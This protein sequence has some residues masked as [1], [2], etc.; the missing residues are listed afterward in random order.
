[1]T[2]TDAPEQLRLFIAI[3]LPESV[4]DA[5]EKA[6]RELRAAVRS[7]GV[8]WTK[9]EQFHL[10]LKF[11]GNVG[12]DRVGALTAGLRSA[13]QDFAPLQMRAETAGFFPS[14]RTPRVVWVGVNDQKEQLA[15]LQ[16]A[17]EGGVRE[18]TA[19]AA[20]KDFTGH[21][22]L[23]R[24]KS[25]RRSEADALVQAANALAERCFG[26]WTAGQVEL[27]RSELL[28]TGPRYSCIAA[29]P[30]ILLIS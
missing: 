17:I 11:L 24:I 12:A 29:M 27:I 9:R 21:I 7:D 19:E 14:R 30:L 5:I 1:M 6:Q 26:E 28:P 4:K 13:C 22:T 3:T 8:R 20:E 15:V 23:G 10:T 16:R 2:G 18:F 25:I